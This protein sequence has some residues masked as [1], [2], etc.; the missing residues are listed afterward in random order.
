MEN[1]DVLV[2]IESMDSL[3]RDKVRYSVS[4]KI[5]D[6][7]SC[8]RCLLAY[9]PCDVASIEY[10][11]DNDCACV[12]TKKEDLEEKLKRLI[13]DAS[14][15]EKYAKKALSVAKKNHNIDENCEKFQKILKEAVR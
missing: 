1:S 4:T 8:G 11:S 3:N 14:T 10:L 12:V 9:G 6:T 15:R 13:F 2:H 7:L 5:A